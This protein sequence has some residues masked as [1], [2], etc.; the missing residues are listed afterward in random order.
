KGALHPRQRAE[1]LRQRG[2]VFVIVEI[3]SVNK[4]S[5]LITNRLHDSWV[6]VAQRIDSNSRNQIEVLLALYVVEVNTLPA[7]EDHRVA[8]VGLQ[9]VAAFQVGD[10]L[11]VC[12]GNPNF[13]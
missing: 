10:L 7:L 4:T 3:G 2:L 13:T 1:L 5:G 8:V 9:N 6:C 12:H 11:K